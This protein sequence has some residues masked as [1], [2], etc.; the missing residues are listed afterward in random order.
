V[1][2]CVTPWLHRI[3]ADADA[4]A[5]DMMMTPIG[6]DDYDTDADADYADD[7]ASASVQQQNITPPS[8][9]TMDILDDRLDTIIFCLH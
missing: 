7:D 6:D 1:T 9:P 4:D 3:A 5:D 8:S 2:E